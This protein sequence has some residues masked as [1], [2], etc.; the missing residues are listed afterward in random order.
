MKWSISFIDGNDL[1][2]KRTWVEADT[3]EEA[4][5]QL[6][7]KHGNFD[8]HIDRIEPFRTCPVCEKDYDRADMLYSRDCHG[9]IFRLVCAKCYQKVMAKGYDG[10]YYTEADENF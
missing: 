6:Y 9:I 4:E 5:H 3:E 2:Y 10:E 7:V 1:H 8:H